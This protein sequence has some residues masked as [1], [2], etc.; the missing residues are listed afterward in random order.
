M[1]VIQALQK[2]GKASSNNALR[3]L[4]LPGDWAGPLLIP[5][6]SPLTKGT[7]EWVIAHPPAQLTPFWAFSQNQ[8]W[9]QIQGLQSNLK[10]T[11]ASVTAAAIPR[12]KRK[13][14]K[15]IQTVDKYIF[16]LHSSWKPGL[17]STVFVPELIRPSPDF[18]IPKFS[19]ELQRCKFVLSPAQDCDALGKVILCQP[20]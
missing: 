4:E 8:L 9:S 3:W 10:M 1:T 19:M 6:R 11:S 20:S 13:G 16:M 17:N 5:P 14:Q 2:T 12:R 7:R 18:L 15:N